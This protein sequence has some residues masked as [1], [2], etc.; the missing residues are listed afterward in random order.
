MPHYWQ[1][2]ACELAAATHEKFPHLVNA[3]GANCIKNPEFSAVV[4]G[5]ASGAAKKPE[6]SSLFN[7]GMIVG[8][9]GLVF[10]LVGAVSAIWVALPSLLVAAAGALMVGFGLWA[11]TREGGA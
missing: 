5:V 2:R 10:F 6:F 4:G 9:V 8:V 3:A 1:L 7:A 11:T